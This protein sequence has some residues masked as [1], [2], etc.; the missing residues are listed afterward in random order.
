MGISVAQRTQ[1]V[2]VGGLPFSWSLA[3]GMGRSQT[4]NTAENGTMA[5]RQDSVASESRT[6]PGPAPTMP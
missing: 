6:P 3:P 2:Q 5:V 1:R 4:R